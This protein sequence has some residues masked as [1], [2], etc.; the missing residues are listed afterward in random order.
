[1]KGGEEKK[2]T[3]RRG[4]RSPQGGRAQKA[5]LQAEK[6]A[7]SSFRPPRGI[8]QAWGQAKGGRRA[9]SSEEAPGPGRQSRHLPGPLKTD[10]QNVSNR[11]F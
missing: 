8:P 1:M 2:E 11:S 4:G 9:I 6:G 7:G 5:R 10:G 3:Q